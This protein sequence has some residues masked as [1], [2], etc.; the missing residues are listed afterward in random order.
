M[1][2]NKC[3]LFLNESFE[4]IKWLNHYMHHSTGAR[5]RSFYPIFNKRFH[6]IETLLT[7]RRPKKVLSG[8]SLCRPL[9]PSSQSKCP[10][11]SFILPQKYHAS[12]GFPYPKIGLSPTVL[13]QKCWFLNYH[14]I[15]GHIAQIVSHC[16]STPF[17]KPGFSFKYV[18][19]T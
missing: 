13:I 14:A 11:R 15:F 6:H 1:L 8:G 5:D 2:C 19:A 16:Q 18:I 4:F 7:I 12:Q 9:V 17:G 3:V 10:K